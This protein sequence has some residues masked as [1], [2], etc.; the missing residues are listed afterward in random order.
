MPGSIFDALDVDNLL[1]AP[2]S[3][4]EKSKPKRKPKQPKPKQITERANSDLPNAER[5]SEANPKKDPLTKSQQKPQRLSQPPP[6]DPDPDLI[7]DELE[8]AWAKKRRQQKEAKSQRQAASK[9]DDVKKDAQAPPELDEEELAIYAAVTR[10][11]QRRNLL[12]AIIATAIVVLVGG[13]FAN[14]EYENL[15][16]PLTP[17]QRDWLA[18]RGFILKARRAANINGDEGASV[19]VAAGKSFADIDLSDAATENA[20]AVTALDPN[21][22]RDGRGNVGNRLRNNRAANARAADARV[23][24]ARNATNGRRQKTQPVVD[25]DTQ[26]VSAKAAAEYISAAETFE[27]SA[28]VVSASSP[29]GNFLRRRPAVHQGRRIKWRG[30]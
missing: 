7:E 1:N 8:F 4:L 5:Q 6:S 24:N 9:I 20:E 23:A 25:F 26:V 2:S 17:A 28:P 19:L 15:S 14:L 13:F 18:D 11:N 30:F 21:R 27:F 12:C 10:Q 22:L 3:G 29:Q 16:T